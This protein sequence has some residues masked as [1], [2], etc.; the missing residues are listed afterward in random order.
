MGEWPVRHSRGD[1]EVLEDVDEG[2]E[3]LEMTGKRRKRREAQDQA[4]KYPKPRNTYTNHQHSPLRN[5][6]DVKR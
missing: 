1:A 5:C 6:C 4:V 3:M 2:V